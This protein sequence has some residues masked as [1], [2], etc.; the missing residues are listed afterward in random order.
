MTSALEDAKNEVREQ[1]KEYEKAK[2]WH[3]EF[4]QECVEY[5]K[6]KCPALRKLLNDLAIYHMAVQWADGMIAKMH[7]GRL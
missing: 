5:G 2:A 7:T 1:F 6:R 4:C 3:S